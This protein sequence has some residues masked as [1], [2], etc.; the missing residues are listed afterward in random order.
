MI[1][2]YEIETTVKTCPLNPQLADNML[3][4]TVLYAANAT[5]SNEKR[6]F[7]PFPSKAET[8]HQSSFELMIFPLTETY[9]INSFYKQTAKHSGDILPY[10]VNYIF[11]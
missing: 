4:A 2:D 10:P 11:I 3:P 6:S 1:D 9:N 5:T 8:E 7:N